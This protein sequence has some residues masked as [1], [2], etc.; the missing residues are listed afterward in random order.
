[1]AVNV[2]KPTTQRQ[3]ELMHKD[4]DVRT[5]LM[6]K[7]HRGDDECEN[8]T[9]AKDGLKLSAIEYLEREGAFLKRCVKTN[10]LHH[11]LRPLQKKDE[12]DEKKPNFVPDGRMPA[13][14]AL[15]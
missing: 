15:T 7:Q 2:C 8:H 14:Q 6:G 5:E 12:T 10:R 9:R 11:N 1:M 3:E 4:E 13:W